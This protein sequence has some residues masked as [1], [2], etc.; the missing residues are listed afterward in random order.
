MKIC[1]FKPLSLFMSSDYK[2]T[3]LR[4]NVPAPALPWANHL[5]AP[6]GSQNWDSFI[7]LHPVLPL[8]KEKK[9]IIYLSKPLF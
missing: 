5:L 9:K 4:V 7:Y 8:P 2:W 1:V 6:R 3:Q